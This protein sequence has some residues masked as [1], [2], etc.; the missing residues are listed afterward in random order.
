MKTTDGLANAK[1]PRPPNPKPS[2][3]DFVWPSQRDGD[4]K[5]AEKLAASLQELLPAKEWTHM[6]LAREMYGT[7]GPTEAPRN[8]QAVRRYLVGEIPIPSETHAAYMAEI[9]GVSMAR[10]LEPEGKF[11]PFP[12]MIRPRRDSERF[13]P[14]KDRPLKTK[15]S[16]DYDKKI[17]KKA[18]AA[19]GRNR[20]KEKQREYNAAYRARQKEK[21]G[22]KRKYTKRAHVNGATV[23][24]KEVDPNLWILADG[25]PAPEYSF[26]SQ[27]DHPGHL[28]IIVNAVVPTVRALAILRMLEH[29]TQE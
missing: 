27:E 12:P 9:L 16:S 11:D 7:A 29:V 3:K 13:K 8:A 19:G 24:P 17:K 10:L 28:K 22:G 21:E 15:G 1:K 25:V 14:T 26:E 2:P 6:D 18:S 4:P 23:I 20:D 5:V